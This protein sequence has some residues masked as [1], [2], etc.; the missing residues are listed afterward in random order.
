MPSALGLRMRWALPWPCEAVACRMGV[1]RTR[2]IKVRCAW[3]QEVVCQRRLEVINV[4]GHLSPGDPLTL[5]RAQRQIGAGQHPIGGRGLL[6][7][8]HRWTSVCVC[9]LC[10]TILLCQRHA[11]S[12]PMH[13]GHALVGLWDEHRGRA[14]VCLTRKGLRRPQHARQG[15]GS[16]YVPPRSCDPGVR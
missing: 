13:V 10:H 14:G 2:H 9:A 3:L 11:T 1:G 7:R 6:G 4:R 12:T 15:R 5:A 8:H 16:K